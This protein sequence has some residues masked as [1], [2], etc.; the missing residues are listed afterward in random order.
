M[1]MWI[2]VQVEGGMM[3]SN[4]S[5]ISQYLPSPHLTVTALLID[6]AGFLTDNI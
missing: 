4:A 1:I 2:K 3:T 6:N 5:P